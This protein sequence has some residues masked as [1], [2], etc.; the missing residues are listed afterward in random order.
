MTAEPPW[1]LIRFG[2]YFRQPSMTPKY[3]N[4]DNSVFL[5]DPVTL[6]W[7]H[8]T[9]L[10]FPDVDTSIGIKTPPPRY[11]SAV[12]FISSSS[13]NWKTK[14]THRNLYDQLLK[15]SRANYEGAIAD[16]LLIIGGFDG[17]SGSVFDGSSSGFFN[18][19]WMLRFANWSTDGNRFKQQRYIDDHC[20]WRGS[21]SATN[22]GTK[23]CLSQITNTICELKDLLMLAWCSSNNQTIS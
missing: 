19:M 9:S 16:S 13:L 8:V 11:L 18:D 23:S 3:N 2:G 4:Y 5:L 20:G 12:S 15:S 6:M 10:E 17:S 1:G 22:F 21:G 14:L 7:K